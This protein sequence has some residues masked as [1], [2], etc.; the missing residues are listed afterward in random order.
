NSREWLTQP[1][2]DSFETAQ[3]LGVLFPHELQ[4]TVN[5]T[6]DASSP[7]LL[8]TADGA[9]YYRFEVLQSQTYFFTLVNTGQPGTDPP[10]IELFDSNGGAID[11]VQQ[12]TGSG[13][14]ADLRPG[15]Y[16]LHLGN[17]RLDQAA[18]VAYRL[19]IKLGGVSEN[20]TP[21]SD[22]A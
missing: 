18:D 4:D 5:V 13:I 12:G 1:A 7:E 21:L 9:D 20:P 15:V 11:A 19:E 14:Q 16:L 3:D 17:W 10:A 22:G 6:R 2:N 8:G